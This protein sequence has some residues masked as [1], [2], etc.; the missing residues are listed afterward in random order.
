VN[1]AVFKL[2]YI[3]NLTEINLSPTIKF[4]KIEVGLEPSYIVYRPAM[5]CNS[6][7]KRLMPWHFVLQTLKAKGLLEK[8]FDFYAVVSV[9]EETFVICQEVTRPLTVPG[10]AGAYAAAREAG[11]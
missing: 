6:L 5:L 8:D 4:L 2:P 7:K 11:S 10:F 9:I 1:I 3:M